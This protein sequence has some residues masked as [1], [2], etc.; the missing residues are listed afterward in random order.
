MVPTG[1]TAVHRPTD[2]EHVG[3][4][5]PARD[6]LVR[7]V[8]LV[9]SPAGPPQPTGPATAELVDRGLRVLA[10]RRWCRLRD[11]LPRGT[12]DVAEPQA[13]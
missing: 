2:G 13:D 3:W 1:W 8:D 7:P 6:G 12:S 10:G 4:L 5:A 11:P 9:G